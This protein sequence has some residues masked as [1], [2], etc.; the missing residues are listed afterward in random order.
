M[1][2]DRRSNSFAFVE[3]MVDT[4]ILVYWLAASPLFINVAV[5]GI[6][7]SPFW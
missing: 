5:L 6:D 7:S 3:Q 1:H 4:A 2:L